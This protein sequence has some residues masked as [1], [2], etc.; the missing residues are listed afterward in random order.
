M[1]QLVVQNC[2]IIGL[3]RIGCGFDDS[4]T[5]K[6]INTHASAYRKN[7]KTNLIALCDIDKRKLEKYGKKFHVKHLYTNYH[8]MLEKEN[9]DCLS[10]CTWANSHY[11]I[12]K[13]ASKYNVKGI[14]LEK[15]ISN[16]YQD[17]KKIIKICL[18]N[19]IRLQVDHQRRFSSF[20]K[21]I[22]QT[23]AKKNFGEIQRVNIIYGSGIFNTGTHIFDL[24]RYF[25]SDVSWVEAKFSKNNPIVKNDPNVDAILQCKN[26]TSCNLVCLDEKNFRI[27][28]FDIIG[29]NGRLILDLTNSQVKYFVT[30]KKQKGLVYGNLI[31]K[32]FTN[33]EKIE[34][35]RTGLNNLLYAIKNNSKTYCDGNDGLKSLEIAFALRFSASNKQKRISLPLSSNRNFII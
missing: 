28:E 10:I 3:G 32:K 12:V 30:N 26:N 31:E 33:I 16:S 20:H 1:R 23:M 22:K 8:E 18:K 25:F 7:S 24:I 29:S 6:K 5:N 9:I 2:A 35:I 14:F 13:T 11:D 4:P 19:N 15:P 21:K 27:L 17:A 34:Y